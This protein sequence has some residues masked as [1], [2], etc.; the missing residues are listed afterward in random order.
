MESG[1]TGLLVDTKNVVLAE[2]MDE[3]TEFERICPKNEPENREGDRALI[4]ALT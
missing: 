1:D 2:K 4:R 3:K